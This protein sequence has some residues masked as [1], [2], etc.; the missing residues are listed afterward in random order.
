MTH[1]Y[2]QNRMFSGQRDSSILSKK[3]P[4]IPSRLFT[5]SVDGTVVTVHS[6]SDVLICADVTY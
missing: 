2:G 4:L 5:V 3:V 6:P 1:E